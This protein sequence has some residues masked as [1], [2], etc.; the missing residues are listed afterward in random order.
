ME[1][2]ALRIRPKTFDEVF[3]QEHLTDK[4]AAF[5]KLVE[6]NKFGSFILYGPCGSGKT[7]LINVLEQIHKIYKFNATTF[8]VK[9]LRKILAANENINI[10][11]FIE[12]I[13]RL[14][15]TQIDVLLPHLETAKIRLIACTSEN[16]FMTIRQAVLSRCHIYILEPLN[17]AAIIKALLKGVDDLKK[18]NDCIE[19][20]KDAVKCI[21]VIANKDARRALS[22]L[23]TAYNFNASITVESVNKIAPIKA[24]KCSDD[25]KYNIVSML[26][27]SIQASDPDSAIYALAL[28]L[29]NGLDPRY[30]ARRLVVSASEDAAGN[31]EVAAIAQSAYMAACEIGRP[32]CDLVLAHA[33]VAI[34]TAPRN[35]SAAKAVWAAIADIRN[36]V[37]VEIPKEMRDSHYKGAAKMGLGAYHDGM[38]PEQYVGIS[39]KYYNKNS[40]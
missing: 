8:S 22:I 11:V 32:E 15:S 27:G 25:D 12:E 16:P 3:G 18:H 1:P 39:K 34:A 10:T 33:T 13:H 19:I 26:Q 36:G 7:S 17:Q 9:E 29:E 2:L 4:N 30:I 14:S 37:Y 31:P 6:A 40:G 24:Y 38:K 28:G 21:S 20:D 5:R 23:E 35:K